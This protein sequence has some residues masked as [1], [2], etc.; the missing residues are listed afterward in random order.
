[1][2]INANIVIT[3]PV[4]QAGTLNV[5]YIADEM[6]LPCVILPIPKEAITAKNA[7][8][9]PKTAPKVLFGSAFFM[10]YIGPPDIS[11][12]S[13]FS[14]YLMASI[15]S[16]N[17]DVKPN[18][19]EIH[20]HTSA[21]GPPLTIA[22]ATPTILPVPIVAAKAVVKAENGETSPSPLLCV[23]ASLLKVLLIA[24]GKFLQ[25]KK[26]V[27]MVKNIP[28]PTKRTNITGPQ[29]KSS[30]AAT[31]S[32]NLSILLSPSLIIRKTETAPYTMLSPLTSLL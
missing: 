30:T 4:I 6:E 19:A 23:R 18:A 29:T 12:F 32:F 1:M 21:P 31:I 14:R 24:Y 2:M 22:V 9:H 10:V 15:H 7:N 11:P 28:V 25:G 3:T 16:L 17:F 27:L 20:I 13:F 5:S 8:N 26:P